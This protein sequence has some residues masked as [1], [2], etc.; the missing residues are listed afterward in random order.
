MAIQRE[1]DELYVKQGT[2]VAA[3]HD[4]T[5]FDTA[6]DGY[7]VV[8]SGNGFALAEMTG[9][10][11]GGGGGGGG[12]LVFIEEFVASGAAY[13]RYVIEALTV[14]GSDNQ[15]L[16]FRTSSNGGVSYDS[17]A[18]DYQYHWNR[19]RAGSTSA[20]DNSWADTT[21]SWAHLA[22][23]IGNA[24]GEGAVTLIQC[25]NPRDATKTKLFWCD[26]ANAS[27]V[28]EAA[29]QHSVAMRNATAVVDA[30]RLYYF[31][32][33][34]TGRARLYGVTST[35]SGTVEASGASVR[36][37]R[38]T[39]Q[40]IANNAYTAISWD[41]ETWD[42]AGMHDATNPTR[43]TITEAGKYLVT[44]HGPFDINGSGVR[45]WQIYKNGAQA[46]ADH[47]DNT[48]AA[49]EP[50]M[51]CTTIA[52]F[53][54]GDYLEARVYQNSGGA[55]NFLALANRAPVFA[56]VQL[57]ASGSLP[58]WVA[59]D[60]ASPPTSP[61]A[62]NDEFNGSTLDAK[63]TEETKETATITVARGRL[64]IAAPSV[65][66]VN[67][68][69]RCVT[70]AVPSTPWKAR[71]LYRSYGYHQYHTGG[72][73]I[74]D[75]TGK[76]VT[77]CHRVDNSSLTTLKAPREGSLNVEY[78]TSVNARSSTPAQCGGIDANFGRSVALRLRDDGTNLYAD[79]SW[80][81]DDDSW[82]NFWSAARGAFIGAPTHFGLFVD[83]LG[84]NA[85]V[86]QFDF[87]RVT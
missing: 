63:W 6:P 62:K 85:F 47:I 74:R 51:G 65:G 14:P 70:Q 37:M 80:D 4:M 77:V 10:S 54:V 19:G 12:S 39:N 41:T 21:E 8:K 66:G 71:T 76:L 16:K 3:F 23:N 36:L 5:D 69:M 49:I 67:F 61:H 7:A 22:S 20:H 38:S 24:A 28:G 86:G 58:A 73:F 55:L 31:S 17:G 68:D 83:N 78:M 59:D 56:C 45:A 46:I 13:S 44:F 48:L 9:G 50:F 87:F 52:E 72:L 11:G 35:P 1:A 84:S 82:V 34:I 81:G 29:R 40:S 18:N 2:V 15:D 64:I 60:P 26:T 30:V 42:T 43:I 25:L 57:A 32:G 53:A 79:W 75:A 33:T 27:D